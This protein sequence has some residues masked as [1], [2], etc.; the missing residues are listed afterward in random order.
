MRFWT[1][2]RYVPARM[3]SLDLLLKQIDDPSELSWKDETYDLALARD[4]TGADRDAL[5]SRLID[6]ARADDP[7]AVLTL[8][9]IGAVET[10]PALLPLARANNAMA[11][12]ARRAVVLLGHGGDVVDLIARDAVGSPNKMERVA[13]V[14]DLAKVGG[15]VAIDALAQALDD[16]EYE[17]REL[18][19]QGL[20][21]VFGLDALLRGPD[22]KHGLMTH[23]ELLSTWMGSSIPALRKLG[24][25]GMR[26]VVQRLRGGAT[27]LDL[28]WLPNPAPQ[29]F[30]AIRMALFDSDAPYPIDEIKQLTG[31]P[32]QWAETMILLRLEHDDVRVPDAMQKLGA[33]WAVPVMEDVASSASA[34]L[35]DALRESIRAL[36][37]S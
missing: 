23:V 33:E 11:A 25:D 5:L 13:A 9:Y 2:I 32:R 19:W 35:R 30:Q 17:I 29:T 34:E 1:A 27:P 31:S 14:M 8:G 37:A 26:E 36:Q 16:S 24:V 4:V 18:A 12:T 15:D 7:R 21:A 6:A 10:L 28:K 22:G 3:S 20:V